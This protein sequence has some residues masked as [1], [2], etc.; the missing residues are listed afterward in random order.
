MRH[1]LASTFA[2]FGTL[3][4]MAVAACGSDD[5]PSSNN[6]ASGGSA[7]SVS[8][9][10]SSGTGTAGTISGTGPNLGG[11]VNTSPEPTGTA[12]TVA[13]D[14]YAGL[15]KSELSGPAE[16]IDKVEDGYCTHECETDD[17]CCA[18]DGECRT[19]FKQVCA[20]FENS[21]KK[22]CFLSCEEADLVP[23]AGGMTG[24]GGAVAVDA[25]EYCEREAHP[26]FLCRSTGGG[27]ENRKACLPDGGMAGAGA[28]GSPNG[29]N[30]QGGAGGMT[31]EGGAA[32]ASEAGGAGGADAGAGGQSA[33]G[34][35]SGGAPSVP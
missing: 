18:L 29:P 19:G 33:G 34:V 1:S 35:P 32:G 16:C 12:C 26:R 22:Y 27:E 14:C 25:N 17:D 13:A 24:A 7:G 9:G 8:S 30:E 20:S 15:D 3:T 4:F 31:S 5:E 21:T 23:G 6:T 10:G 28:G 2:L 11:N